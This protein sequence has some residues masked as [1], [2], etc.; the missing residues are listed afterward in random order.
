MKIITVTCNPAIDK[1]AYVDTIEFGGLNRLKNVRTDAG[2][3]GINVSKT[4]QVFGID[5]LITGFKGG[6]SGEQISEMLKPTHL[7]QQWINVSSPNR[8]NLKVIN[9]EG[10]CTELNEPGPIVSP[11][12]T[13]EL[14]H[15]I[16]DQTDNNTIV[17][18]SGSGAGAMASDTYQRLVRLCKEKG[19]WVMLDADGEL[20]SKA[21]IEGP[22][23]IKP[24]RVECEKY[25][26]LVSPA[27]EKELID[28]AHKW[29]KMGVGNIV[30]SLGKEGAYF[31]NQDETLY[32]AGMKVDVKSTVGAGDSMVASFAYSKVMN[33][34]FIESARRA[35]ATSAA[36]V[37]TPSTQPASLEIIE[38]MMKLV[39]LKPIK[40][41]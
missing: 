38:S 6:Q 28:C 33:E 9:S 18:L 36:T 30:L 35:L 5:S 7:T 19:A 4:L 12:E 24:N 41:I 23:F 31:F 16:L 17:I 27:S 10:V 2:G 13:E 21:V 20:F 8:T 26:G 40:E 29:I 1:T 37:T 34:T 14:I 3:K 11:R 22:D 25:F 39:V 32:A 15:L